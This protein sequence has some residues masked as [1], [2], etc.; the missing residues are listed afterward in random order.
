MGAVGSEMTAGPACVCFRS[1]KLS[2]AVPI[3]RAVG[4]GQTAAAY[5]SASGVPSFAVPLALTFTWPVA[6]L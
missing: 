1:A 2:R 3:S 4:L 6:G 5:R